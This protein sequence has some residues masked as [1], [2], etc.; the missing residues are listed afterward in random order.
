MARLVRHPLFSML[1]LSAVA[2]SAGCKPKEPPADPQGADAAL[3]ARAGAP[4]FKDMGD[5]HRP[6]TT[7]DGRD[8][9]HHDV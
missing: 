6:I 2:L 3:V 7:R 8:R 5:Y 1:L 4:L 9:A